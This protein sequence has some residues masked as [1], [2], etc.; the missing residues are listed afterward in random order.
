MIEK[1][2]IV[3]LSLVLFGNATIPMQDF[4]PNYGAYMSLFI[5]PFTL[6]GMLQ[7][8]LQHFFSV[9]DSRFYIYQIH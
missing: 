3:L 2:L 5:L 6:P 9:H 8:T 1:V 4:T 7:I